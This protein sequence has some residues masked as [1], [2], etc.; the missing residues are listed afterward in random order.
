MK[1]VV[2]TETLAVLGTSW[3]RPE[4]QCHA[5]WRLEDVL[6]FKD[7]FTALY[8]LRIA[9]NLMKSMWCP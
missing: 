1:N 6:C 7:I 8:F 5:L 4:F 2:D 9:Q 3:E